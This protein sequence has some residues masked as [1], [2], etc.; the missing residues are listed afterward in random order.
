VN[1]STLIQKALELLER[2]ARRRDELWRLCPLS[3]GPA[4][5]A[6]TAGA[7]RHE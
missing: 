3:R 5:M 6:K 4:N 7:G 2:F 1:A